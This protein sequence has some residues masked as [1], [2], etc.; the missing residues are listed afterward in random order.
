MDNYEKQLDKA[1][2]STVDYVYAVITNQLRA[3][4][5][6]EAFDS[7]KKID[8]DG[9]V[10]GYIYGASDAAFQVFDKSAES[11]KNWQLGA[12]ELFL[13]IF[14]DEPDGTENAAEDAMKILS[15]SQKYLTSSSGNEL[16]DKQ[17]QLG[18]QQ[19]GKEIKYY[20]KLDRNGELSADKQSLFS[21]MYLAQWLLQ[22]F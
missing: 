3:V 6:S 20:I 5:K 22:E 7:S 15:E 10:C 12:F 1:R 19:G 13:R 14:S 21:K 18:V 4:A 9:F 8:Y 17:F 2:S 16:W 11:M